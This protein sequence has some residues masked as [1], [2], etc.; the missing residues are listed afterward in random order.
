MKLAAM[1][2]LWETTAR[3]PLSIGGVPLADR[4]ETVLAIRIPG[5]LS[6]LAYG[7]A[8]AVVRGLNEVPAA[9]RPNTLLV[10]LAFQLM[11]A[12]GFGLIGLG[13][14]WAAGAA[15]RRRRGAEHGRWFL[16]AVVA[17]GPAAFA[18]IESGW[19]VTEVGRQP[20][21]VFGEMRTADAVTTNPGVGWWLIATIGI[22]LL[23]GAACALLLLR[24]AARNREGAAA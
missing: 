2:G 12:V 7:D 20:W 1:E 17:A 24:L 10:H 14:W 9:D 3:A 6:W 16:R 19:I 22:Y 18:A 4:R 13:I 23:L 5:G 15:R 11:V 21:V 8:D